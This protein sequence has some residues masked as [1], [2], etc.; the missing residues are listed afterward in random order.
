MDGVVLA[1][2]RQDRD[3]AAPR[4]VHHQRAGHH[5]HFLVRER[6]GLAGVDRG[7]H[8]LERRRCRTRRRARCRRP[9]AS[10][11]RCRPSAP[12]RAAGVAAPA[13]SAAA[14]LVARRRRSRRRPP[15]AG[16]ARSARPAARRSRRPRARRPRSRSAMR[17][18]DGE[19]AAADR[20]GRSE[21]RDALHAIDTSGRGRTPAR[22]RDTLST[23]SSTPPWP[24]ISDE[25]SF[26]PAL[27]LSSDSKRSPAMPNTARTQ[28]QQRRGRRRRRPAT[29]SRASAR[30]GDRRAT[31]RPPIAPSIVLAGTDDAA[32]ACGGRRRGRCSTAPSRCAAI[33]AMSHVERGG[34]AVA[35]IHGERRR[36]AVRRRAA[37][38]T[39]TPARVSVAGAGGDVASATR[40]DD[41]QQMASSTASSARRGGA[42]GP[43]A[44]RRRTRAPT[45]PRSRAANDGRHGDRR[46]IDRQPR[47]LDAGD[48]GDDGGQRRRSPTSGSTQMVTTTSATSDGGASDARP[49]SADRYRFAGRRPARS[50]IAP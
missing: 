31:T 9:D 13:P 46:P 24:G 35:C 21:N 36:A 19:R 8:G 34:P 6:D 30:A 44:S 38:V 1:V 20:S 7:E 12:G 45:P 48:R 16:T 25:L 10:R 5:E 2:H 28:R 33:T 50:A 27:R 49:S 4:G 42:I 23:R 41:E 17:V 22:R 15:S 29:P 43:H 14:Q 32:R 18:D 11:R 39:M 26:T 3:A 37:P 47:Q 40:P